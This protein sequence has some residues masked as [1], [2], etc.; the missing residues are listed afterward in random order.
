MVKYRGV[1]QIPTR[2]PSGLAEAHPLLLAM[3]Y[4]QGC[5]QFAP[6]EDAGSTLSFCSQSIPLSPS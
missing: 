6:V 3:Q 1:G 2:C 4:T 5:Q